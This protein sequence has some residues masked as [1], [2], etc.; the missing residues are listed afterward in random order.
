MDPKLFID[1]LDHSV[2]DRAISAAE[3]KTSGT[4]RIHISDQHRSDALAA[5]QSQFEKLGMA[6]TPN[7]NA[8]L[9]YFA[10]RSDS[11]AIVGDI[12]THKKCGDQVWQ[13]SAMAN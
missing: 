10:P 2:L 13:Q 6:N 5:A 3:E 4:I 9:I 12:G 1:Q 7:R 8:V 11:F